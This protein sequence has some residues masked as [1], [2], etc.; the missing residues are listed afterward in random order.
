MTK[1]I[2]RDRLGEMVARELQGYLDFYD[3]MVSRTEPGWPTFS[4]SIRMKALLNNKRILVADD[5]GVNGKTFTAVASKFSLDDHLGERTGT[6][7]VAPNSGMLNAWSSDEVNRYAGYVRAGRQEV[8]TI[9]NYSGLERVTG[10]TDF[11]GRR[12][13]IIFINDLILVL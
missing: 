10:D 7:V 4:Q 9:E 1:S 6:L 13:I 12:W 8:V 3:G 11:A 5:T 2:S